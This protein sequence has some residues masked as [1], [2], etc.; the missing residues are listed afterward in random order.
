M[1]I[2]L[3][4]V[5]VQRNPGP[6]TRTPKYPYGVHSKNANS[7]HKV[8]ECEDHATWCHITCANTGDNMHQAHMNRNSYTWACIKC[9]L[10]NFTNSSLSTTINISNF[11]Q[12]LSDL[13]NDR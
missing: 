1:D 11:I 13:P 10:P 9:G 6:P 3:L 8:M 2:L 4:S 7:N 12:L 5:D